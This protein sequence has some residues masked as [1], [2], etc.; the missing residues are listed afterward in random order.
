[1]YKPMFAYFLVNEKELFTKDVPLKTKNYFEYSWISVAAVVVLFL[2]FYFINPFASPNQSDLGTYSESEKELAYNEVTTTL[3][4]I[5]SSLNKGL[6]KMSHLNN[7][8]LG[9]SK[10]NYLNELDNTTGQIFKTK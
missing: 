5:S 10:V 6:N 1:M 8:E 7:M 4:L 3:Q 9:V 2:G